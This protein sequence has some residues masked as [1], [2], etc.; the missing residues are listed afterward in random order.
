MYG[1]F[2]KHRLIYNFY[3]FFVSYNFSQNYN[4]S[5]KSLLDGCFFFYLSLCGRLVNTQLD[6][7]NMDNYNYFNG[8]ARPIDRGRAADLRQWDD[9]NG[10]TLL[11]PYDRVILNRII[12][13]KSF[14]YFPYQENE[15]NRIEKTM[16]NKR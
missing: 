14:D 11:Q 1:R 7:I 13:D 4:I 8:N 6:L 12:H 3:F 2:S 10:R 16:P 15:F 5:K 9:N